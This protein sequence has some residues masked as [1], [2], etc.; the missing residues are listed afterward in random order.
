M[1]IT[2]YAC[3]FLIV[4]NVKE[5]MIGVTELGILDKFLKNSC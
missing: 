3:A 1:K 4:V 2:G 5:D